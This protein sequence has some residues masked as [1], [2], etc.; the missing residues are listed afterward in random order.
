MHAACIS[1][2]MSRS[3]I[4]ASDISGANFICRTSLGDFSQVLLLLI[5]LNLNLTK[6]M[7]LCYYFFN[8][9]PQGFVFT[10]RDKPGSRPEFLP[11]TYLAKM[12]SDIESQ[13]R[14]IPLHPAGKAFKEALGA[15]SKD[16]F[17][18]LFFLPPG[19]LTPKQL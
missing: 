8:L 13:G 5:S 11:L 14:V 7:S 3:E 2:K 15:G 9:S 17:F 16:V 6:K 12:L 4:Y 18:L 10:G 19:V 1:C